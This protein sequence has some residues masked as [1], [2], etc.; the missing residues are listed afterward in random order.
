MRSKERKMG[1][2]KGDERVLRVYGALSSQKNDEQR[3]KVKN[4]LVSHWLKIIIIIIINSGQANCKKPNVR[5]RQFAG[6]DNRRHGHLTNSHTSLGQYL[7]N[8]MAN[9]PAS[10]I[11][12]GAPSP[13]TSDDYTWN[14]PARFRGNYSQPSLY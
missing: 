3:A 9:N 11:H 12:A 7:S 2:M 4:K 14:A 13:D 5:H 6:K 8:T 10:S 1:M